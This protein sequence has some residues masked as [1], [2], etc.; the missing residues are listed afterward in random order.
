[1][2]ADARPEDW[3]VKV[4]DDEMLVD[5]IYAPSGMVDA[6]GRV[7]EPAEEL[8]VLRAGTCA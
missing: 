5:L 4:W 2:R 3:L 1:M 6:D 8:D 7:I